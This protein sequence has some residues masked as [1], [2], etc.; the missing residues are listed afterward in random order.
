MERGPGRPGLAL[1]AGQSRRHGR[2]LDLRRHAVDATCPAPPPARHGCGSGRCGERHRG[3]DVDYALPRFPQ[4]QGPAL[5]RG[6]HRLRDVQR[7][8]TYL[9]GTRRSGGTGRVLAGADPCLSRTL[10]RLRR[11]PGI[12]SSA[13]GEP[14]LLCRSRPELHQARRG[15]LR[16]ARALQPRRRLRK[17]ATQGSAS[18]RTRRCEFPHHRAQRGPCGAASPAG[19]FGRL[20]SA[21]GRCG[22]ELLPW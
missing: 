12:L 10:R 3:A 20:A 6:A 7:A 18:R 2:P 11:S 21:Q 9:G 8:G 4:G 16:P 1:P 19:C 15:G 17:A 22:E 14:A 13:Q 5:E